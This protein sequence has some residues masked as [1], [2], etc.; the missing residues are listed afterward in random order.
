MTWQK[1]V[2]YSWRALVEAG[3]CRFKR[4]MADEAAHLKAVYQSADRPDL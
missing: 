2:G 4:V 3:I 1:A